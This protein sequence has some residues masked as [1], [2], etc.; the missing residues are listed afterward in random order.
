MWGTSTGGGS[1]IQGSFAVWSGQDGAEGGIV[2][3]AVYDA[4]RQK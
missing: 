2:R 1:V 3:D 4:A